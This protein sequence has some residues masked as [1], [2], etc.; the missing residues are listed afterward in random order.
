[1]DKIQI[2]SLGSKSYILYRLTAGLWWEKLIWDIES[3]D[4]QKLRAR[5]CL[6]FR[7]NYELDTT[8]YSCCILLFAK[9]TEIASKSFK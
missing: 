2:S 9:L 4:I 3:W 8:D 5:L 1:M 7:L 6:T